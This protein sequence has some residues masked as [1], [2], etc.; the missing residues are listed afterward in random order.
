[1]KTLHFQDKYDMVLT[2]NQQVCRSL[3]MELVSLHYYSHYFQTNIPIHITMSI[4]Y[5]KELIQVHSTA[6]KD[7]LN[8]ISIQLYGT[9]MATLLVTWTNSSKRPQLETTKLCHSKLY[10]MTYEDFC[11]TL[12]KLGTVRYWLPQRNTSSTFCLCHHP[13][14]LDTVDFVHVKHDVTAVFHAATALNSTNSSKRPPLD[15]GRLLMSDIQ[16]HIN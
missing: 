12:L 10:K 2:C 3:P 15:W 16:S 8:T 4:K 6:T 11:E 13:F 1:M 5:G 14:H 7:E 9:T